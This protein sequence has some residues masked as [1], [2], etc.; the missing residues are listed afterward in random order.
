MPR[1]FDVEGARKEGYSDDEI[2]DHLV[3]ATGQK[4]DLQGALKEGY[5]KPEIIDQLARGNPEQQ[6]TPPAP[7]IKSSG[8]VIGDVFQG[9]GS[10]VFSSAVGAYDLARKAVPALPEPNAYVRSL[11]QP[12]P[13]LAGQAGKF[14]EQ[15]AEFLI[16]ATKLAHATKAA[17]LLA[18]AGADAALSAGI[19]AVQTG[20]DKEAALTAGALGGVMTG[21][22]GALANSGVASKL[23]TAL[24]ESAAKSYGRALGATKEGLKA[25]SQKQ[26]VPGLLERKVAAS[27]VNSLQTKA[28]EQVAKLGQAIDGEWASLPPGTATE[29]YPLFEG[30]A[31]MADESFTV[32]TSTG[33]RV[34]K[35]PVAENGVKN[36][37]KLQETLLD[38]AETNPT[39]GVLEIPVERLRKLRQYWDE[40]AASEGVYQGE[41]DPRKILAKTHA[42][43]GNVVREEFAKDFPSIAAL[44]KEFSFWKNVHDVTSATVLRREG[45][46]RP[47][48]QKVVGALGFL[49]GA[50]AG[51]TSG[52][53][54]AGIGAGL[55]A[56]AGKFGMEAFD[57]LVSS[58]GWQI[59]SALQKDKLAD[60]LVKGNRGE[61]EFWLRKM[62]KAAT[63]EMPTILNREAPTLRPAAQL[64]Q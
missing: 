6:P 43:A 38:V 50:S 4:F 34:A 22:G 42:M 45:Q 36:V 15:G 59:A 55:G 31:K 25:V 24:K 28:A 48:S 20:G 52:A 7:T 1:K 64:A 5:A 56:L 19:S 16:P 26:A 47:F 33:K 13:T 23:S 62:M 8:N 41:V 53:T 3:A 63:L 51:A 54:E 12:P 61:A 2:L 57:K 44:N 32:T 35:S 39:T 14:I 46:A 18:R 27:S 21:V 49:A 58:G 17:P 40:I 29:V 30:L 10:G 60:A 37:Q 9:I 11:T